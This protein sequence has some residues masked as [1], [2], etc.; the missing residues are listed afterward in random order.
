MRYPIAFDTWFRILSSLLGVPPSSCFVSLRAQN[1]DV[2]M[3]WLFRTRFPRSAI[4]AVRRL[5][6]TVWSRG[7]HGLG[8]RWLVNGSG[9]GLISIEF[10]PRQRAH[11]L[12]L[13]VRLRT[14]TVSVS[15]PSGLADVLGD[16]A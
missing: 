1:V 10:D 8:G 16:P 5:D 15:D 6:R 7:V 2:R 4:V 13:P 3:G 12:G 9:R 11:V 14:L